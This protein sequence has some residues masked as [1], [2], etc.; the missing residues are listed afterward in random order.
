MSDLIFYNANVITMDPACPKAEL[1]AVENGCITAVS[2]NTVIRKLKNEKAEVMDCKGKTVIPG[3]IDAH[4]HLAAFAEGLVSIDLSPQEGT[5]SLADMRGKI[6]TFC[7]NRPQDTWI[8]GKGYNEYYLE[9]KRHPN[10]H[11]LD[12]AAPL[13][14][15]KLTHR[16]G[17][18]HVLNSL[19]L[20]LVGITAESGDPPD[21]LIDRDLETGELTGI[22]FGMGNYLA[23]RIPALDDDEMRKGVR[24]ANDKLLSLGITSLQDATSHNDIRCWNMFRQW[25]SEAIFRPEVTMMLGVK[26]FD[27]YKKQMYQFCDGV[28]GLR[29]GG[30]K[31]II[32]EIT[33]DLE[34]SQ[35][36]LNEMVFEIHKAGFQAVLHAVEER[37]IEAACDAIEYALKQLPRHDHRHRIEHCS[38]CPPALAKRIGDLG[39]MVVTQPAFLYYGGDRYLATVPPEQLKDLYTIGR[40]IKNNIKVA[41]SSDFP[42]V[43]PNPFIGIYAAVTRISE[44]GKPVLPEEGMERLEALR[45]FTQMAAAASFE[46]QTRGSITVGKA[47]D[48]VVLNDDPTKVSAAEIKSI[49]VEMTVINGEIVYKSK[50][51]ENNK[52]MEHRA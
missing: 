32:H 11:D 52:C 43:K 10:R 31:I 18:A 20:K 30:V 40:L 27:E 22:L 9:E 35:K 26:G 38:V 47:A 33:G 6:R 44:N 50:T 46:E 49:K 28:N 3:F 25:K 13:H 48:L 16:S 19:G 4:C 41:G 45:M 17:H 14:P 42:I 7:A 1:V 36:R 39:I 15:V 37:T 24:L 34:P 51:W 5:R 12:K 2:N 23:K 8:R 29:V 21:G